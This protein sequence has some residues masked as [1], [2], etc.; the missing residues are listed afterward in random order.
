M[1]G[2]GGGGSR[3]GGGGGHHGGGFHGGGGHRGGGFY[4]GGPHG[5]WHHHGW[6]FGPFRFGGG[7]AALIVIPLVI[8]IMLFSSIGGALKS[9]ISGGEI[10]YDEEMFEDYA[11]D[12]YGEVFGSYGAYEDNLLIVVLVD[13]DYY[14]FDYISMIGFHVDT[15]IESLFSRDST[16]LMSGTYTE[17]GYL[18]E[19]QVSESYKYTLERDLSAVIDGL[20]RKV[21]ALDLESALTC[22]EATSGAPSRLVNES[23]IV[24]LTGEM[25]NASLTDFSEATGISTVILVAD[26]EDV[27]GRSISFPDLMILL[28]TLALVVFVTALIVSAVRKRKQGGGD[29]S[30]YDDGNRYGY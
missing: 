20:G 4:G 12:K 29:D 15:Q 24:E 5:G 8:L 16:V 1:P 21:E 9:L 10:Y 17:F 23:D 14:S 27:F 28:F 30:G 13:E 26:R 7:L 19:S 3:G 22:D 25:I 18:I 6:G 11:Y 2:R